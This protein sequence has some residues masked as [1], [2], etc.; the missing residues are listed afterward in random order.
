MTCLWH[1]LAKELII[2]TYVHIRSLHRMTER[3]CTRLQDY[4]SR[5]QRDELAFCTALCIMTTGQVWRQ[6]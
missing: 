3:M 2:H 5:A 1:L 6:V 4:Y